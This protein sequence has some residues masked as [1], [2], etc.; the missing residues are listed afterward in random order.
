MVFRVLAF[1][2]NQ[3]ESGSV[4]SMSET[5]TQDFKMDCP[6]NAMSLNVPPSPLVNTAFDLETKAKDE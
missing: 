4:T 3:A 5:I 1:V 6:R 2:E